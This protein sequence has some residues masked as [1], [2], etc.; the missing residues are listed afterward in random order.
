MCLVCTEWLKGAKTNEEALRALEETFDGL[1]LN[2][3]AAIEH[4]FDVEEQ[5]LEKEKKEKP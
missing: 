5:I 2:D 3:S 4:F 1:K